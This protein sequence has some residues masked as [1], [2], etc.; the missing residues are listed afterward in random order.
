VNGLDRPI[1]IGRP[2]GAVSQLYPK[3]LEPFALVATMNQDFV[4]HRKATNAMASKVKAPSKPKS[5]PKLSKIKARQMVY[6]RTGGE[7][8]CW[9]SSNRKPMNPL[10]KSLS[11]W[12]SSMTTSQLSKTVSKGSDE[13]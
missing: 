2:Y 1:A 3:M 9:N 12:L 7:G 10:N 4:L 5:T 13:K 8:F 11:T 6:W